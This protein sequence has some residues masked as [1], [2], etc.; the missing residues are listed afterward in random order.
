MEG[1]VAPSRQLPVLK[2]RG[3]FNVVFFFT[4]SN[5]DFSRRISLFLVL[6]SV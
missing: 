5:K 2:R 6:V 4:Y 3:S 1:P